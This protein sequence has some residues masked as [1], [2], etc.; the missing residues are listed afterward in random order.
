MYIRKGKG[1]RTEDYQN[2]KTD[3]KLKFQDPSD[4]LRYP[5]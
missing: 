3:Q 2:G 5:F 4:I 1:S